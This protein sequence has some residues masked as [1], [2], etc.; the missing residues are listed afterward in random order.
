MY[1]GF[2]VILEIPMRL[3]SLSKSIFI[4]SSLFPFFK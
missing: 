1:T 2:G 3:G 4:Y